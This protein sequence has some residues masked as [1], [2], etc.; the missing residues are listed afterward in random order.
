MAQYHGHAAT[1]APH[2]QLP[3]QGHVND[4]KS[5]CLLGLGVR[6]MSASVCPIIVNK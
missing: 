2:K 1:R 4:Y 3:K 6:V 5:L